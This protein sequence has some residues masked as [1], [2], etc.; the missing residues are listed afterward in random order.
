M[1]NAVARGEGQAFFEKVLYE[2]QE[3]TKAR[4]AR[5]VRIVNLGLES[6]E[7]VTAGLEVEDVEETDKRKA[8]AEYVLDHDR[9]EYWEEWLQ[10]HRIELKA[11]TTP[12]FIEWLDAKDEEHD[13]V[14]KLV[15]PN[16]VL[17]AELENNLEDRVRR[18]VA[19][20]I[21]RE[22]GLDRQVVEALARISRPNVASLANGIRKMYQ[23][24]PEN[25]WRNY[26]GT[27]ANKLTMTPK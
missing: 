7:A 14:V 2:L 5:K 8:G 11:M 27:T 22:A 15:P 9:D 19:D 13:A 24:S 16:D 1:R 12:Q 10:S 20:R 25:E 6:W 3:E 23:A 18:I 21:L 17:N 4:G 26:I